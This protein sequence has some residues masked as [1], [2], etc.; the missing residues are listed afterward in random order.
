MGCPSPRTVGRRY[1]LSA[2]DPRLASKTFLTWL[3]ADLEYKGDGVKYCKLH[4]LFEMLTMDLQLPLV[5]D[6]TGGQLYVFGTTRKKLALIR[7]IR[8]EDN[9]C[10]GHIAVRTYL[11][12]VCVS[13][14]K[15]CSL[16][17]LCSMY[18]RGN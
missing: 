15:S 17:L 12:I 5:L 7:L 18:L 1:R 9:G 14:R 8:D 11:D 13:Q 16:L 6:G 10:C 2:P 3:L 4:V